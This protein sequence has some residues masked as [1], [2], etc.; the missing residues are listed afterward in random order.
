MADFSLVVTGP[1]VSGEAVNADGQL[2]GRRVQVDAVSA[3]HLELLL[4]GSYATGPRYLTA[5]ER[6]AVTQS[7]RLPDGMEW[8]LPL[9]LRHEGVSTVVGDL[10]VLVDPEAVPVAELAVEEVTDSG[11]GTVVLA[12]PLKALERRTKRAF[13]RFRVHPPGAAHGGLVVPTGRP[14]HSHD[15]DAVRK[16]ADRHGGPVTLL[17]LTGTGRAHPV[18]LTR[19]LLA[20]AADI[21]ARVAVVP[22]PAMPEIGP[23]AENRFVARLAARYGAGRVLLPYAAPAPPP[24]AFADCPV[25]VTVGPA[26]PLAR[27]ALVRLLD[28][29]APLPPGYTPAGVEHE[30]RRQHPPTFRRGLVLLFTGLSGSGKS[31]LASAVADALSEQSDRDVS[32]LDGDIVRTLL[33]ADL[34]FSRRDRDRNVRRVGFV[35]S[36]VARHG[37]TVVLAQIA[38]YDST[39]KEIRAMISRGG[40]VLVLVHVSTPLAV[41][42]GRDRKGL[43][44][45]A[46]AG[47]IPEFTG[48]SDPYEIPGDAELTVDTSVVSVESGVSDIMGFLRQR[49]LARDGTTGNR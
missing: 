4:D 11:H 40:G 29:G 39:R 48:V 37:G 23:L 44:A 46:R 41:C 3:D 8:E 47:L 1:D 38:P 10:L 15:L 26:G 6:A 13:D 42:E 32:V 7:G 14:L 12:G 43:Y 22:L 30:L 34:T 45:R 2:P 33:S 20:G 36:E 28:D 17:G 5:A 9:A 21:A 24:S 16:E 19:A 27:S 31:T 35:A 25:P 49:G 18:S